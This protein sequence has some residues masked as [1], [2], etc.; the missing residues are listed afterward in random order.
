MI[1]YRFSQVRYSVI[2]VNYVFERIL[3]CNIVVFT[4]LWQ[5]IVKKIVS[6]RY[7]SPVVN[8]KR[9]KNF[10]EPCER[11]IKAGPLPG[12]RTYRLRATYS[13]TVKIS[14][15]THTRMRFKRK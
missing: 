14:E 6:Y 8:T 9:H 11:Q 13:E 10:C 5:L 12:A 1:T 2:L 15:K 4:N 3:L 7:K